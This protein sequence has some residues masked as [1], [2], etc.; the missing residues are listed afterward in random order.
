MTANEIELI[1]LIRNYPDAEKAM[2]IALNI[3]LANLE[4]GESSATPCVASI[5]EQ[6]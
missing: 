3:I 1:N 4:Q 5:Q 6:V 2:L